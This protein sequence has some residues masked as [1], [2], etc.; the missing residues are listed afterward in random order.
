MADL[1]EHYNS[2][3]FG[4]SH[5]SS[6]SDFNVTETP[7]V[8]KVL[9]ILK[10]RKLALG[11]KKSECVSVTKTQ[12]VMTQTGWSICEAKS[13][14]ARAEFDHKIIVERDKRTLLN[15]SKDVYTLAHAI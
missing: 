8:H 9:A 11:Y 13:Q 15:K 5:H 6:N 10:G 7:V 14:G 12:D 2:I 3:P 1:G 4:R